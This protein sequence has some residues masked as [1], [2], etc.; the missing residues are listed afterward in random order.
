MLSKRLCV[1]S[2]MA[3]I[4]GL[5]CGCCKK[6]RGDMGASMWVCRVGSNEDGQGVTLEGPL[7]GAMRRAA[8]LYRQPTAEQRLSVGASWLQQ[9][10]A[11]G[12]A[13]AQRAL[14]GRPATGRSPWGSER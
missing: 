12:A 13:L 1:M 7:A 10:A 5:C 9:A 3:S 4:L 6:G 8:Y 2:C 11:E 14:S